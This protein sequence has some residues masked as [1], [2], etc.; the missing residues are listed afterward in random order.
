M[1][2]QENARDRTRAGVGLTNVRLLVLYYYI[3]WHT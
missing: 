3:H 2:A 1:C